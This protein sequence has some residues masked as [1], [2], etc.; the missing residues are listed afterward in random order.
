M[1]RSLGLAALLVSSASA[2]I[3]PALLGPHRLASAAPLEVTAN[4]PVWDEFGLQAAEQ[5]NY[6]QFRVVAYRFKDATG[7]FAAGQ[8]LS[9]SDASITMAGNYVL[10]CA[11]SCASHRQLAEWFQAATPPQLS[12]A[13]YPSLD[14]YLPKRNQIAGSKRYVLGPQ[15][16]ALFEPR[17]PASAAAFDFSTEAQLARYRTPQ[18]E[19]TL[20]IFS[21]PT[22]GM[23]RQQTAELEKLT[24]VAVKRTG[25]LIAVVLGSPAAAKAL[26]NQVNYGAVV[27]T[28]DV[29][30]PAPLQMKPE[31]AG[32]MLLAIISLAGVVLAFCVL[33]GLA[34]GGM[35]RV[36]RRFGYSGADGSLITLHL[37]GK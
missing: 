22:P 30:P 4:R 7:A 14:S 20:A 31:T 26:L 10:S 34:F 28:S 23:A 6:G 27:S 32:Q 29:P 21:F 8:W 11:G 19:Q 9:G 35:L 37:S 33:S 12:H 1:L 5:A 3:W 17:I 13:S 16:L 2:A 18:G 24:D 25:P 15:S 36:A